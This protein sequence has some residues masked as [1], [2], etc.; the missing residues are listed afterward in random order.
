MA[1]DARDSASQPITDPASHSSSRSPLEGDA[2]SQERPRSGTV[3]SSTSPQS[4]QPLPSAENSAQ[5][6]T[7][8]PAVRTLPAWIR[9]VEVPED[10]SDATTRLL[11]SELDEAVVAQ[12]NHSPYAKQKPSLDPAWQEH[13]DQ[14]DPA[15]GLRM[16]RWMRFARSVA[17]PRTISSLEE[18]P[19]TWDWLNENLGDYANKNDG[20]DAEQGSRETRWRSRRRT[21][22]GRFQ[23]SLLKSPIVPLVFRL[24]VWIFSLCAL[25]LGGS[26]Y[27][28]SQLYNRPQGPSADMA[29]I[30]DA[31]ALVYLVYITY[32][33]YTGKP[34]G[35]RSPKAKMRLILLDIFFIVFDSANLSLA[36][37]SLSDVRGSC[38]NSEIN[39]R[40]DEKNDAI[41]DRQTALASV[42]LI[43]LIAWLLTF[44]ISVFRL[45]ERVASK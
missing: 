19:V 27:H 20:S 29:I 16:S 9:S 7:S 10:E 12:H 37:A 5:H 38:V 40:V 24:T 39:H 44:T 35:L 36:F 3:A 1:Q 4:S 42:L 17:Y 18:K 13:L 31:V 26:I 45:V 43:A 23:S 32:D 22:I 8:T 11:P 14:I 41:C 28:L 33:E 15:T 30:V 21:W 25:A 34:L 2:R 6:R